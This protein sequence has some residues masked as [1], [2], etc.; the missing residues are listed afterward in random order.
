MTSESA[1]LGQYWFL[2]VSGSTTITGFFIDVH[3][4][5]TGNAI[6]TTVPQANGTNDAVQIATTIPADAVGAILRFSGNTAFDLNDGTSD[7]FEDNAATLYPVFG[8]GVNVALGE[9]AVV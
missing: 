1:I 5:R 2:G 3:N 6:S 4:L 8:S 9:V 7:N